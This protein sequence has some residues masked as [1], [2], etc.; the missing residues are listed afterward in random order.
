MMLATLSNAEE[1]SEF[2]SFGQI[3]WD[4]GAECEISI[5]MIEALKLAYAI[6]IHK[7][8]GSQFECVVTP[9]ERAQNLDR[10]MFYKAISR[11]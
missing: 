8:Q 10:T 2:P 1:T 11:P 6:I 4:D 9:L 3:M 5:E 7:S